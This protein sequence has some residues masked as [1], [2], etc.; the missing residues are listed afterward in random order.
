MRLFIGMQ[1]GKSMINGYDELSGELARIDWVKPIQPN[2]MHLTLKFI[3]DYPD[4]KVPELAESLAA[5]KFSG[6]M[7][8][9]QG[10][11]VFPD[12]ERARIVWIGCKSAELAALAKKIAAATKDTGDEREFSGHLTIG[13]IKTIKDKNQMITLLSRYGAR[14]FGEVNVGSFELVKSTLTNDGAIYATVRKFDSHD[15]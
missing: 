2:Q 12:V 15:G 4:E 10:I 14:Q 1:I 9:L 3:G 11:G 13:R 8:R 5:V 6:F 7:L